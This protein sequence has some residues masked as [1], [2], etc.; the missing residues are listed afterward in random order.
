MTDKSGVKAVR[1]TFRIL[2]ALKD[3]DGSVGVS[4]LS[5]KL[6]LPVSTVHS[7][8]TT[9]HDCGYVVKQGSEYDIGY[10]FLETG[11][12]RRSQSRLFE[13]AKPKVDQLAEEFGDKVNLVVYDHGLAAHIY[14]AKGEEAIETDTYIGIRLHSHSSASGKV[15]LAHLPEELVHETIDRYGLVHHGPNAITSR[16]EFFEELAQIREAG[17]AFDREER[18]EGLHCVAA[19][20]MRDNALPAAISISGP[21]GRMTGERFT[22]EI[23]ERLQNVADTIRIKH[24]YA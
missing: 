23:P 24:R 18:V 22:D 10:R 7:H 14:I 8:L 21:R 16:D 19:P 17:I 5:D 6:E 15:I 3:I 2:H 9:L 20:I 11:G 4:D 1:T 12:F 13:F